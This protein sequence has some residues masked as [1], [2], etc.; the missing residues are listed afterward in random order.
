MQNCKQQ[1]KVGCFFLVRIVLTNI[2]SFLKKIDPFFRP[3]TSRF[4]HKQNLY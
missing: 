2:Y 3:Q 1:S 4:L